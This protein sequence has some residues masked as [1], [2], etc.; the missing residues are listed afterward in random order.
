M[1]S[2]VT[3]AA[4]VVIIG[5]GIMGLSVAFHLVRQSQIKIILLEKDLLTQAST[6]LSVGG[7]RQ[8]FSHPANI[9]LSQETLR[10]FKQSQDLF[11]D[12]IDFHQVGY[13]FLTQD[14]DMWSDFCLNVDLQRQYR[15]PVETLSPEEI[16]SQWPF[17]EAENLKGGTFC[18]EDGY[19]D[20]YQVAMTLASFSRR[21]GVHIFEHTKALALQIKNNRIQ[22]VHTSKGTI[23]TPIV[24]NAA[25]PWGGEVAKMAG[26]DIPVKP[27][28]RQVFT[29]KAFRGITGSIPM[30]IDQDTLFYFRKEGPGILMGMSDK[31]EPSSFNTHVTQ[32][33]L[34]KLI[35]T[36]LQRAPVLGQ[37]EIL[38]GWG[39]LYAVTPDENPIIGEISERR[40]LFCAVGFSGHGFQ[41]GPAVGRILSELILQKKTE[42]DISPFAYERFRGPTDKA[43]RRTV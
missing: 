43:E 19:A 42:F 38:R 29:T 9:L 3:K 33:F 21:K 14:N 8:Q 22:G 6:G 39:G 5:G 40:G 2:G 16:K 23:S 24:V 11:G 7:I 35:E 4:D 17:L 13:L 1:M 37:A 12:N 25:G 15:V 31:D 36:A 27:F 10:Q 18:Q 32:S 26:L 41:H 28:R 30:I 34:E 20:P